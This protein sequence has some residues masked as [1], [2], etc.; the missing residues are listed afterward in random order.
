MNTF[1]TR[2]LSVLLD[3]FVVAVLSPSL[4]QEGCS[5]SKGVL[6]PLGGIRRLHPFWHPAKRSYRI[7]LSFSH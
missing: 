6:I 4:L 3:F 1:L 7:I 2:H 5:N